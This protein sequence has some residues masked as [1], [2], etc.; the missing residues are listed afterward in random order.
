MTT[1]RKPPPL[2]K[3]RS[4]SNWYRA[5]DDGVARDDVSWHFLREWSRDST[6]LDTL[7][8]ERLER[9]QVSSDPLPRGKTCESCLRSD[10]DGTSRETE[11]PAPV[12][13]TPPPT[14]Q[15]PSESPPS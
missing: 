7:C 6:A 14:D 2:G 15:P 11:A 13:S 5:T 3:L 8:G 10:R 1:R 9:P 12:A 4:D